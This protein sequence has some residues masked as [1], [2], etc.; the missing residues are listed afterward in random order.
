MPYQNSGNAD[1]RI[2]KVRWSVPTLSTSVNYCLFRSLLF[3][4]YCLRL[5][6]SHT[7]EINDALGFKS[8]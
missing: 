4:D 8:G 7:S 2:F 1:Y 6:V 3:I 5:I